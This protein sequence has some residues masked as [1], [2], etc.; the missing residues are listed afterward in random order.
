MLKARNP[1]RKAYVLLVKMKQRLLKQSVM[2]YL[3][4]IFVMM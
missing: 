3:G 4:N 1:Y 2:E